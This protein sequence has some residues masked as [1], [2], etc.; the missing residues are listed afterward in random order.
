MRD[1]E[2]DDPT[3]KHVDVI[4][5][6]VDGGYTAD[7]DP[8]I[9]SVKNKNTVI[10]FKLVTPTPDDVIIQSVSISPDGQGQL[11]APEIT[12]NGK[13]MELTD[14]NTIKERFHLSFTFCNKKQ[15]ARLLVSGSDCEVD[16]DYP[17]I[18]N[19]PP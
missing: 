1:K 2:K 3:T 9:I 11:S 18:E 19:N 5:T 15:A 13:R 8:K 14:A 4:V 10:K 6:E 17:I 12:D 7:Y 16:E